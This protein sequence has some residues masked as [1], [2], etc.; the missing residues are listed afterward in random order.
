MSVLMYAGYLAAGNFMVNGLLH[1][2]MGL[3]GRRFVRRPKL[4]SQ[5]QYERVYTGRLFSSAVFNAV[6][7]LGQI[8][9]VL[10]ALAASPFRF[11]LTLETGVL[12]AGITFS[13]VL[14]AWKYDGAV[15]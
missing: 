5:R 4:V 2:L 12:C 3:L 10:V 8:L 9:V 1:L 7:G 13:T 15:G 11:G 6:Y 14:L